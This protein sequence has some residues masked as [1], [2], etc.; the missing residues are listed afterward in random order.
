MII[1]IY[2]KLFGS[3]KIFT[4]YLLLIDDNKLSALYLNHKNPY[5]S[6]KFFKL[7]DNITVNDI[8]CVSHNSNFYFVYKK[9]KEIY[10]A[11]SY[12]NNYTKYNIEKYGGFENINI[13]CEFYEPL[14]FVLNMKILKSPFLLKH[15][16]EKML[17]H[18]MGKYTV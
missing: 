13:L 8:L 14:I 18:I 10:I 6:K 15:V 16:Q 3:H 4:N 12:S 9:D 5:L 17:I 7:Y 11:S 2:I 1:Y